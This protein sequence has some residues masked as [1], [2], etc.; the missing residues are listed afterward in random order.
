[1]CVRVCA[2]VCACVCGGEREIESVCGRERACLCVCACVCVCV[3]LCACVCMCVC[4]RI[5]VCS[6]ATMNVR[7]AMLTMKTQVS[8]AKEPYTIDYILQ[9]DLCFEGKT[10]VLK[11]RTNDGHPIMDPDVLNT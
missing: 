7:R 4:R 3:C 5:K 9:R 11:A 10:C 8:F 2:C 1:M 6:L